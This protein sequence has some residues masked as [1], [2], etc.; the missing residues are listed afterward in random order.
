[1][2]IYNSYFNNFIIIDGFLVNQIGYGLVLAEN[3]YWNSILL[4]PVDDLWMN[5]FKINEWSIGGLKGD[6]ARR[7]S[8]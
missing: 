3:Y 4:N 1:M 6:S 5:C 8:F 2:G 7:I